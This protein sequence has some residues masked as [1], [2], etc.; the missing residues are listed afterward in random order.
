MHLHT[1]I[2]HGLSVSSYA[3][4]PRYDR[5][6]PLSYP[7][8]DCFLLCFAV[9]DRASFKEAQDK[10]VPELRRHCPL[11]PIILVGT[12]SDLRA[13]ALCADLV[14]ASE[15]IACLILYREREM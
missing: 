9:N 3:Q 15:G 14:S 13:T 5:L 8:T 12:K 7:M 2:T 1:L 6:R 11:A 4:L 10:F